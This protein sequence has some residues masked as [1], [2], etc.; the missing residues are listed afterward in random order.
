MARMLTERYGERLHGVLSCYDRMVITGTLPGICYAA[1]M[2]RFLKANGI[3]IFDYGRFA[4]PLR[5]RIGERARR[6]AADGGVGIE[7]IAKGH[8]RKEDAVAEVLAKR[9]DHP[10]LVH[11]ISAMEACPSYRPWHDKAGGNTCIN[12]DLI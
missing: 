6:L 1:G 8:I 4:E 2:T 11:V 5:D 9:G 10:G 3:W 7:H 12:H